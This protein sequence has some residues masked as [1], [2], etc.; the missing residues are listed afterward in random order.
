MKIEA[1]PTGTTD[2]SQ[3]R[4]VV[5]KGASGT[6]TTRMREFGPIRVRL[7]DY[8][9][10]YIA[11]DW[12]AKGHILFVVA[13]RLM[14]EHEDGKRHL[15]SGGMTYHGGDDDPSPHRVLSD[16]GAIVFIVD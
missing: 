3:I 8:S 14:I 12:C 9:A 4:P 2:W 11:G 10:G 13:G 6:A 5:R 7:I 15:L 1:V 16:G